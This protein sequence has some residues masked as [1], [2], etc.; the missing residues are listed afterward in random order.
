MERAIPSLRQGSWNQICFQVL[1]TQAVLLFWI[2]CLLLCVWDEFDLT[3][4]RLRTG[5]NQQMIYSNIQVKMQMQ[6]SSFIRGGPNSTSLDVFLWQSLLKG[7]NKIKTAMSGSRFKFSAAF[8][9]GAKLILVSS[10]PHSALLATCQSSL[11]VHLSRKTPFLFLLNIHFQSIF[12]YW[13]E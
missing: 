1:P 12:D 7:R 6:C 9:F 13:R 3:V 5:G 4:S 8:S 2:H 11:A 10:P